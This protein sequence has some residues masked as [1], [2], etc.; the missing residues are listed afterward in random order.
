[1]NPGIS[2]SR[3]A[4][5]TSFS[6]SELTLGNAGNQFGALTVD[7]TATGTAN[8][9]E[10]TTLNLASLRAATATLKSLASIITTG[11]ASV[12]ADTFAI[13]AGGDFAPIANFRATNPL[14]VAA[15]GL[16]DLSLLSLATNLNSKAPTVVAGSYKAPAP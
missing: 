1:M 10:E 16:A 4:G 2:T 13:T 7:V 8:I 14:T 6:G 3:S 5:A 11:T 15:T 9:T 12:A